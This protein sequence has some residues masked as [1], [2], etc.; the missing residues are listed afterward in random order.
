VNIILRIYHRFRGCVANRQ[1]NK[2][3]LYFTAKDTRIRL[4]KLKPSVVQR[5][6]TG[7]VLLDGL[8]YNRIF[9]NHSQYL[10]D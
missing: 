6:I 2:V 9:G 4:K 5:R 7:K 8:S 10:T 3:D 1:A